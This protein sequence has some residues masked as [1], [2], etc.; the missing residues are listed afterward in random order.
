M[1]ISFGPYNST[2]PLVNVEEVQLSWAQQTTASTGAIMRTGSAPTP[3]TLDIT[4]QLSNEIVLES[5]PQVKVGNWIHF[6]FSKTEAE[7]LVQDDSIAKKSIISMDQQTG[8]TLKLVL[9]AAEFEITNTQVSMPE[10]TGPLENQDFRT[11]PIRSNKIRRTLRVPTTGFV[12]ELYMVVASFREYKNIITIG[13][14]SHHAILENGRVQEA[15]TLYKLADSAPDYG[16]IGSVWPGPVHREGTRI[17]AG[18]QHS[19]REHPYLTEVQV[20]NIKVKDMRILDLVKQT[21][22]L[23]VPPNR[24]R[25]YLS[26]LEISRT[27]EGIA[28]GMFSF[29]LLAYISTNSSLNGIMTNNAS[30]LSSANVKDIIIYQRPTGLGF[31]GNSLTP[32]GL[33][34]CGLEAAQ[35]FEPIASLGNG[36]EVLNT[37][38]FGP[39]ILNVSFIDTTVVERNVGFTEYKVEILLVDKAIEVVADVSAQLNDM[40]SA[41]SDRLTLRRERGSAQLYAR[42]IETYLSLVEYMFGTAVFVLGGRQYWQSNMMAMMYGPQVGD[43]EKLQLVTAIAAFIQQLNNLVQKAPMATVTPANY[44]S[45]IGSSNKQ[46]LLRHHH[47]FTETLYLQGVANVGLGYIDDNLTP[48][49]PLLQTNRE[50]WIRASTVPRISSMDYRSRGNQEVNKYNV[51]NSEA[52]NVN[53]YGFLSPTFVGLGPDT[54][55]LTTGLYLSNE[56]ALPLLKSNLN[57]NLSL[58][59]SSQENRAA[60]RLD[61]L[62][63]AGVSI[64]PLKVPLKKEVVSP[65]VINPSDIAASDYLSSNSSFYLANLERSEI[66]GSQRS[67]IRSEARE[68]LTRAPLV[69]TM[70]DQTMLNYVPSTTMVNTE[71]IQGSLAVIKNDEAPGAVTGSTAMTAVTNFGS[72]AA[73][74]YLSSYDPEVGVQQQN[75][76]TLDRTAFT[77]AEGQGPLICR[78]RKIT[79]TMNINPAIEL[80]PMAAYFVLG[81]VTFRSTPIGLPVPS[82]MPS[83]NFGLRY[84]TSLAELGAEILYSS[85]GTVLRPPPMAEASTDEGSNT[86]PGPSSPPPK[87]TSQNSPEQQGSFGQQASSTSGTTRSA[88]QQSQSATRKNTQQNPKNPRGY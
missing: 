77:D 49:A 2:I 82:L 51:A 72:L 28:Y 13:N 6:T 4:V 22:P 59:I 63:T 24:E 18:V 76:R 54:R 61:I 9:D 87:A 69:A 84:I 29:D 33:S 11:L 74:Q 32:T 53:S 23:Y 67:I 78:L 15:S 16:E 62:R 80:D 17:M 85:N 19:T 10:G 64:M 86:M 1:S 21:S 26:P 20:P 27:S 46:S 81:G 60:Q 50:W 56:P 47:K 12:N 52:N 43:E 75:W 45:K 55:V 68:D 42:T 7:T 5:P 88:Q 35:G 30:L 79:N 71:N 36:C 65:D 25:P 70:V 38:A 8:L 39:G 3:G 40:V 34:Y 44:R 73:V 31:T 48:I 83:P 14:I 37:P 41:A 57:T 58:D 66:S